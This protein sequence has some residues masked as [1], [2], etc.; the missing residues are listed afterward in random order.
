MKAGAVDFLEKP[1]DDEHLLGAIEEALAHPPR[2]ARQ[3]A[4]ADAVERIARL[5]PREREV[6]DGLV[7][8]APFA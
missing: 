8:T 5:S 3:R 4:A 7:G 6:L 1:F 2:A